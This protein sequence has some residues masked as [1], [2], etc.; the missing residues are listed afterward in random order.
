V[1]ELAQALNGDGINALPYHAGMENEQRNENQ[2]RFIR[3]DVTVLVATI[4]FGMGIAKPDVRAVIH[5]D[6]PRSLEGY[7]QES[8]RAGRDGQPAQCILFYSFGDRAK[9]EYLISKKSDEQEQVIAY[10]QLR[11]MVAYAEARQCRRRALLAYF[12]EEY[13]AE[14]CGNCDYCVGNQ[15]EMTLEDRTIDAQKFL[16]CVA[17]TR[18]RFGMRYIVDILRGANTQQIRSF[19]HNQLSTYGIG[20]DKSVE[21]WMRFARFLV[22][23]KLIS[24]VTENGYPVLKLNALSREILKKQRQVA[25]PVPVKAAA[26]T[27]EEPRKSEQ[28]VLTPEETQLF[29]QLRALRKQLADEQ[30]VPPYIVMQDNTL[31]TMALRRPIS[32]EYFARLP[33]IGAQKLAAYFA[34]FSAVIRR[35]CEEHHLPTNLASETQSRTPVRDPVRRAISPSHIVTLQLYQQGLSIAEIAQRRELTTGTIT[36]HLIKAIESGEAIDAERLVAPERCK[37][38]SDAFEQIGGTAL[39]P[40]KDYLGDEYSYDEIKLV[41]TLMRHVW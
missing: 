33:G 2:E 12:G 15:G 3:D 27:V 34:P 41:R 9:I 20:K 18:E 25:M 5:F 32:E 1:E 8:G 21:E 16:S 31:Y 30:H 17:R 35:Y 6:L 26:P 40:I 7:Y 29:Q 28:P 11:E 14:N 23:E 24:Q 38:I 10:Q 13:E 37:A 4:A 36:D 22:Q 39:R 19:E